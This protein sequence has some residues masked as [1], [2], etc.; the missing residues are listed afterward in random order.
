MTVPDDVVRDEVAHDVVPDDV[1][2]DDAVPADA[3]ID[4]G[5][6]CTATLRLVPWRP[7]IRDTGPP[8]A[9]ILELGD[10]LVAGAVG[11]VIWVILLVFGSLLF[12]FVLFPLEVALLLTVV[13]VFYALRLG[14]VLTWPVVVRDRNRT[15]VRVEHHRWL[16]RA[17]ARRDAIRRAN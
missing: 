4:A 7:R 12:P 15:V 14:G 11:L 1:V 5:G 6:P 9:S 17:L 3:V 2:P 10:D 13:P 8:D 16:H